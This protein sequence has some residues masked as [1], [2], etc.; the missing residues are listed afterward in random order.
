MLLERANAG[1]HQ[2]AFNWLSAQ[3]ATPLAGMSVLDLGCGTGAWLERLQQAGAGPLHGV[4]LDAGQFQLAGAAHTALDFDHGDLPDTG[5]FDLVTGL[6][7]IEHLSNPGR[8]LQFA[9]GRCR[10][11][12]YLFI[13]SPNIESAPARLRHLLTGRLPHFD[14]KSDPTHCYPVYHHHLI[15]LAHAQGLHLLSRGSYPAQGY[16]N[17]SRGILLA[18]GLLSAIIPR[19]YSGDNGFWLFQKTV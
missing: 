6:E 15:R 19:G 2:E 13:T 11:G 8:F 10:P 12:G 16:H 14:H 3:I 17:F 7:I 18:A 4:D 1:L 5:T 9:A